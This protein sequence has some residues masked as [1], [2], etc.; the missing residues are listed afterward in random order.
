MTQEMPEMMEQEEIYAFEDNDPITMLTMQHREIEALFSEIEDVSE[1]AA[2]TRERLFEA[3]AKKIQHHTTLEEKIIYPTAKEAEVERVLDAFEEHDNIKAMMRKIA[4]T[5]GKDETF[6]PKIRTLK[7]LV[8]HHVKQ[9]EEKIFPQCREHL[10][11]DELFALGEEM[12]RASERYKAKE[13]QARKAR[14]S[15][16]TRH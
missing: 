14:R 16:R 13:S 6:M 2:K 10:H 5:S 9:E 1:R 12:R 7:E 4:K 8:R 11:E 15:S 3:L